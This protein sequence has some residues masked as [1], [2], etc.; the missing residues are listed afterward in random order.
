MNLQKAMKIL[1]LFAL[2]ALPFLGLSQIKFVISGGLHTVD[3][4]TEDLNFTNKNTTDSF[5]LKFENASYGFH[6]GGG[7]RITLGNFYFQPE[8]I[9]N[10]N[11]ANFKFTDFNTTNAYDSIRSEKY[12]YL[13]LPLILGVKLGLLRL[14][15][16]P[17]AHIFINNSSDLFDLDGYD[18]KFKTAT[19]GYQAGIGFDFK[20][21]SLD[22]R[23]EGN[24]SNYGDHIQF[25]GSKLNFD[26]KA[27][28][29]I[30]TLSFRF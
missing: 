26:N 2:M 8:L 24:F 28:R 6:F 15:V 5:N 14:S 16:G 17:V 19:F 4:G 3:V 23:H 29:L 12:Q 21:V 20:F 9:F 7:I 1:P 18:D 13:D 30:A 22:I 27:T 11:K 25:F 10:S